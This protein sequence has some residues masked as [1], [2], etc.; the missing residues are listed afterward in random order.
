MLW[1]ISHEEEAKTEEKFGP[2]SVEVRGGL[3]REVAL[4]KT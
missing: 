1:V 2:A 4:R 3:S